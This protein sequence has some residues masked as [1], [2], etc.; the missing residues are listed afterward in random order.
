MSTYRMGFWAL[1]AYLLVDFGQVHRMIPGFSHL[2]PGAITTAVLL[3]LVALEAPRGL[4]APG[5]TWLRPVVVW[6][7]LFLGAVATGLL[8]AVTQG[9]ALMVLKTEAPR[10]LTAF[11]G[12]C[13]FIRRVEDLRALQN[14]FIG[15]AFLISA[16]VVT[17]HGHGPGLYID[18][19]DA[20]LV[21]VMLL[22]F[23]CLKVFAG[24]GG[25]L[26]RIALP[27]GVF[28][29][30]L[31]AIGLT[32]SRG[33]MVGTIP[34]LAFC[35]LKSRN[36]ALSLAVG[37]LVLG[38]ALVFA[39]SNFKTEFESIGDTHENTAEA[40][41]YYWDLSVQMFEKRPV[42]GVGA[43]C[44]GN[45]LYSGLLP[46]P[47]RRA[48]MTPHSIYFQ[49]LSELGLV[50]VFCWMGFLTATFRELRELR[51]ARLERGA[52]LVLD[53]SGDPAALARM[54]GAIRSLRHFSACLAIG[55]AG[56]LVSGGFLSVLFYPGLALFAAL[57]Q[58]SGR[59]WRME[60]LVAAVRSQSA[61]PAAS[62][63]AAERALPA[64]GWAQP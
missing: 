33:G 22:P 55:I 39:P 29:F 49:L 51:G 5:G 7:V 27:L 62:G 35:W 53:P 40:R 34:A 42:F 25:G 38:A 37:G 15:V 47:D 19:N 41:R 2:M 13:L 24:E 20:A 43:M 23:S 30:T 59:V 44:W 21:L 9:R 4:N 12:A 16:W 61:A 45:A 11:L 32:L 63:S 52:A 18:E 31:C 14:M 28:F 36:K 17:H 48:H 6:R 58:A 56:Y 3:A 54:A 1:M 46:S 26:R 10:F 50:G 60:L 64:Y 8:L 57:A